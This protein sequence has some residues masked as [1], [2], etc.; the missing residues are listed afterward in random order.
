MVIHFYMK[1]NLILIFLFLI[2]I[3]FIYILQPTEKPKFD[4]ESIISLIIWFL[5]VL[6]S[7]MRTASQTSK[8]TGSDKV[9][10]KDDSGKNFFQILINA[11]ILL[12]C[13]TLTS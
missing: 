5:C 7:S 2:I 8:L 10:L 3:R 12:D 6:Y 9:L 11:Q 13:G 4:T 1:K